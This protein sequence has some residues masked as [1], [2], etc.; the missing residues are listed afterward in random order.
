MLKTE[1]GWRLE[2]PEPG[3]F[4]WTSPLGRVYPVEPEPILAPPIP[5]VTREPETWFDEPAPEPVYDEGEAPDLRRRERGPPREDNTP[6]ADGTLRDG[7][8]GEAAADGGPG[9]DAPPF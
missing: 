9:D 3:R 8:P 2:Q 4:I 7:V 1:G 5:P 6:P